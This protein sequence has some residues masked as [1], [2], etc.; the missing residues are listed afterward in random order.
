MKTTN[1]MLH[2]RKKKASYAVKAFDEYARNEYLHGGVLAGTQC[3]ADI[4]KASTG[5]RAWDVLQKIAFFG[6]LLML[7]WATL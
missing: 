6:G 7:V 1:K 5:E 4:K 3:E 2:E